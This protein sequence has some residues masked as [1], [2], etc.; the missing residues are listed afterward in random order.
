M[1][2]AHRAPMV[3][4]M[5]HDSIARTRS[6]DLSMRTSSNLEWRDLTHDAP[7]PRS[8]RTRSAEYS[9]E[10]HADSLGW[11]VVTCPT[12]GVCGKAPLSW[13]KA[14]PGAPPAAAASGEGG[15]ESGSRP[16][17]VSSTISSAEPRLQG[18]N[19]R[20]CEWTKV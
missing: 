11:T 15:S 12:P 18:V 16:D 2:F 3:M 10:S 5:T 14:A 7:D 6:S 13:G 8:T 17:C 1:L 9:S 19:G 4:N 20:R